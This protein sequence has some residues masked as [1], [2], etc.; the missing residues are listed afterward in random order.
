MFSDLRPFAL[1]RYFARHEFTAR[2]LLSSS[3][4]QT[5]TVGELLAHEPGAQDALLSLPLGYTESNGHPELRAAIARTYATITPDDVLV[6]AG[7]Q[8]AIL[9]WMGALSLQGQRV[10]VQS[11][12]YQSLAEL[13][14]ANGATVV[15][16]ELQWSNSGWTADLDALADHLKPGARA[17]VIN[18]PHNPTGHQ[19]DPNA[20]R[21]VL[22]LARESGAVVLGDE[23]YRGLEPKSVERLPA[24]CDLDETATSLGVLSKTAGLPGLRV[25]WVATR[26]QALLQRMRELKDYTTICCAAPSELLATVALK[27]HDWLA[28]RSRALVAQN[29]ALFSERARAFS[30]LLAWVPPVA[31]PVAFPQWTGPGTVEA[32][33]ERAVREQGVL[34]V[35]GAMFGRAQHVRV[36]LGRANLAQALDHFEAVLAGF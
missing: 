26:N 20:Q 2:W 22:R 18:S 25:G 7:A 12:C 3:D 24:A 14:R 29:T 10:V 31:G 36:G 32:L 33:C 16:W 30:G 17:V 11:P 15:P 1:E 4:C 34:L 8:E 13:P 5:L 28:E 9:V 27:H 21:T 6:F 23:V 19:L 35:P